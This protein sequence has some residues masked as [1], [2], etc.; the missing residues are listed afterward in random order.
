M[1]GWTLSANL[2][3]G[4]LGLWL[5]AALLSQQGE[6]NAAVESQLAEDVVQVA[7]DGLLADFQLTGDLFVAKALPD[8][9]RDL[10]FP[11]GQLV[12][13]AR[14][15]GGQVLQGPGGGPAVCPD[16]PPR[17]GVDRPH[18]RLETHVLADQSRCPGAQDASDAFIAR[19]AC[20][21]ED[22]SRGRGTAQARDDV[23]PVGT[24]C[25][26][27]EEKGLRPLPAQEPGEILLVVGLP[28]DLQG[29]VG[30]EQTGENVTEEDVLGG[31]GNP[32]SRAGLQALQLEGLLA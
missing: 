23:L 14:E 4:E 18:Q 31:D 5:A 27:I 8:A 6:R 12:L 26:V 25:L 22:T 32:E 24:E 3:L 1:T 15:P 21:D 7:L 16:F 13:R 17:H 30:F 11:P 29:W 10:K 9:L 20:H 2:S 19:P 28:D